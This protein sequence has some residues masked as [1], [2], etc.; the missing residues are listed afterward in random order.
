MT[1][2]EYINKLEAIFAEI[3]ILTEDIKQI[4]T[5]AKDEGYKSAK[6]AKIAKLKADAKIASFVQDSK[7]LVSY[8]EAN[9]L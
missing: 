3:N 8:I 4:K 2:Q 7:E 5:E 6:L 1:E 9:S